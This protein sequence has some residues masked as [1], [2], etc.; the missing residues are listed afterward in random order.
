[1][2]DPARRPASYQD[3]LQVSP[4]LTAEVTVHGRRFS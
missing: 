3:L 1:M 2:A 4:H